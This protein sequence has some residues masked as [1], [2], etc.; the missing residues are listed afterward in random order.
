MARLILTRQGQYRHTIAL[1]GTEW[2][3]GSNPACTIRLDGS[4]VHPRHARIRRIDGD[5]VITAIASDG[6]LLVNHAPVHRHTLRDGDIVQLGDSALHFAADNPDSCPPSPPGTLRGRLELLNGRHRGR[7]ILLDQPVTR[8]GNAGEMAVMISRRD[9]G[10]YLSHLEGHT[11]PVINGRHID[12]ATLAL[13]DGDHIHMGQVDF[14]FSILPAATSTAA[15]ASP[16]DNQRHFTRVALDIPVIIRSGN[17]EWRSRLIDL[18]LSG[19]RVRHPAGWSGHPGDLCYLRIQYGGSG[20]LTV[21]ANIRQIESEQ[22]GIAF[23]NTDEAT[24]NGLRGLMELNL[25]D[26]DLLERELAETG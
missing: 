17:D 1:T 14:R 18:S 24:G 11:L 9:N 4:D 13:N 5:Y 2:L 25:G 21:D 12:D 8:F 6:N 23:I 10:Y 22:L 20:C 19:A 26:A 3:V 16:V 15:T 7:C